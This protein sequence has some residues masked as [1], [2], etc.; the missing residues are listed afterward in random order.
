MHLMAQTDTQ[1]HRHLDMATILELPDLKV[2][3][4]QPDLLDLLVLTGLPDLLDQPDFSD[5][6]SIPGIPGLLGRLGLPGLPSLP[7]LLVLPCLPASPLACL[8]PS[9][10]LDGNSQT[11]DYWT[12]EEGWASGDSKCQKNHL[13]CEHLI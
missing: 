12:T 3:P 5:L 6:L 8:D 1:T 10:S 11:R 4:G 2:L 9:V 13:T 7:C